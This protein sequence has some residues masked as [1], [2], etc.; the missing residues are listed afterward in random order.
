MLNG[1][2]R[3]I[4]TD[5]S[6]RQSSIQKRLLYND[7]ISALRE[8]EYPML[9]GTMYLDHAGTTLPSRSLIRVFARQLE[10][11]ILANPHS[12]S[13]SS[14]NASQYNATK[15]RRQVLELFR[16]DEE[17]FDI[18]F[19]ANST[20]G[21][22][23]V[24]EAFTGHENGFDYYYH[25]DSHTSLVG[26]RELAN[27]SHCFESDAEVERWIEEVQLHKDKIDAPR[28]KLFAY[29][30]QSNMNGRRLPLSWPST[31]HGS[32]AHPNTYTLLDVAALVSTSPL[33]LSDHTAAPDFMVLSF[34][35]MFGFPDLGG[36]IV[37]KSAAHVFE[38]RKYFGGGTTEMVTC[39][40][41]PWV[42]R[43]KSNLHERLEDGTGAI[44]SILALQCAILAH[45][46][47]FGGF[48]Q[49]SRHTGWL[50][51]RL[52]DKMVDLKHA[53]GRSACRIYKDPVSAYGDARSQGATIAF[54]I[55][56]SDGTWIG[57]SEVRDL[58]EKRNIHIRTGSLCN[59]A[60][61]AFALGLNPGE[62]QKLYETGFRCGQEDDVINSVPLG[63]AKSYLEGHISG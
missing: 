3:N 15:T 16:A 53:N 11:T 29:P 46:K 23:L 17:H 49:I 34:Y 33:D 35:K 13:S 10:T 57:S 62:L 6:E 40:G 45:Y 5:W 48:D 7:R 1:T 21:I 28:P 51:K 18:I 43:K 38:D 59:P 55:C 37:R 9:R 52:Y 32:G 4:T 12:S 30:A 61:M 27:H 50:A 60:G 41:K 36:V 20:A 63:M 19:V 8:N 22:K 14:P 44:H 39:T 42:E 26:V 56:R 24:S 47:L 31:L 58:A 25:Q 54:N 2:F